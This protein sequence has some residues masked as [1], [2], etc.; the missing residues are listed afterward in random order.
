MI[1]SYDYFK[2]KIYLLIKEFYKGKDVNILDVG[3]GSGLYGL[4]LKDIA[5]RIDAVEIYNPYI[6][7]FKLDNIYD[8]VYNIDICDFIPSIEYDL[9]IFGDVL[10]HIEAKKAVKLLER[11]KNIP[12]IIIAVP[13]LYKQGAVRG[14]KYEIHKQEDL[15]KEIFLNRYLGYHYLLGNSDYGYFVKDPSIIDLINSLK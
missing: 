13:Y 7:A 15:T 1:M 6:K 9:I 8:N 11:F 10:E 4:M 2:D 5:K 12:Q 3:A 14:N